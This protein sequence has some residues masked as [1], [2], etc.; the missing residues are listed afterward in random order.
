MGTYSPC[1][2]YWQPCGPFDKPLVALAPSASIPA[3]PLLAVAAPEPTSA[4]PSAPFHV[5]EA[6]AQ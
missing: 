4:S 2:G 3:A 5:S 6:P 1:D